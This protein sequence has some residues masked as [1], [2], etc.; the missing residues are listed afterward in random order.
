MES[1]VLAGNGGGLRSSSDVESV[2]STELRLLLSAP[3]SEWVSAAE[4]PFI[5]AVGVA[6]LAGRDKRRSFSFSE[7]RG[8]LGVS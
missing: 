2:V 3:D 8:R 5:L 4:N 6:M 1:L 7:R